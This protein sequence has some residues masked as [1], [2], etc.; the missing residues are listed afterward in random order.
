MARNPAA[1]RE[2][3][4]TAREKAEDGRPVALFDAAIGGSRYQVVANV[5]YGDPDHVSGL[6]GFAV[7]LEWVRESY[8]EEL[9]FQI[10]RIGGEPDEM[11]LEVVDA[12]GRLLAST[13]PRHPATPPAERSFPLVFVDR[14]FLGALPPI[15]IGGFDTWTA[16]VGV[17]RDS[18]MARTAGRTDAT[19]VLISLAALATVAGLIVTLRGVR[20]AAELAAMKSDFVSGVTHEL[21][22]PLA[23]IRLIADTLAQGRYDSQQTVRDYAALLGREARNLGRLIDN[24]LAYARMSDVR[25]AYTFEPLDVSDLVEGALER[26][27]TLLAEQRFSVDVQVPPD[28]PPVRADRQAALQAL[29]NVI[30]NAIK[31]SERTRVVQIQAR[32]VDRSVAIGVADRGIGIPGGELA[33]VSD[34]FFRGRAATRG[35][36]GLGLAI[37]REIVEAHGGRLHI[38]SRPGQ[39]TRVEIRLPQAAS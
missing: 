9:A 28:L 37:V 27:R 6:V 19:F 25:Q 17:A 8:V 23:V 36:S 18:P 31:Y 16:R 20:V 35:G 30:D 7:N 22:T 34:K 21:K 3:V 24:L 12:G 39:G 13:R 15:E 5:L 2:I 4:A 11:S 1:V 14:A 29:D 38:E 10:A 26:F 32:V 33:R